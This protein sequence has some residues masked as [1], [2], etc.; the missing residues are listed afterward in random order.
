VPDTPITVRKSPDDQEYRPTGIRKS[1]KEIRKLPATVRKSE[2]ARKSPNHFNHFID[3]EEFT[4]SVFLTHK[5]E[6][7]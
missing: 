1:Y 4:S 3:V 5:E 6:S 2:R 7:D